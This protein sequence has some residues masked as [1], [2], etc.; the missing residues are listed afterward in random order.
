MEMAPLNITCNDALGKFL[1]SDSVILCSA[2]LEVF[3]SS[4][5]RFSTRGQKSKHSYCAGLAD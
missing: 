3:I 5:G 2:G 1:L 4:G